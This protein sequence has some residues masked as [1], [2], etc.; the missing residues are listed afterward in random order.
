MNK[1][2]AMPAVPRACALALAAACT[3]H[4]IAAE[5]VPLTAEQIG[6]PA[7]ERIEQIVLAAPIQLAA[8]EQAPTLSIGGATVHAV[9]LGELEHERGRADSTVQDTKLNGDVAN[10]SAF[11]VQTGSNTIDSGSFA[12]M[13]GIPVVIQNSGANVLIQNATVIN[14]QFQ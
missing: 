11:N 14:L 13:S 8:P 9:D 1:L 12:N 3:G 2:F 4:A 7:I 6:A 10:N 5:P